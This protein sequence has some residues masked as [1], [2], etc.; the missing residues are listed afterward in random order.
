MSMKGKYQTSASIVSIGVAL[1]EGN[2]SVVGEGV[3]VGVEA[4]EV[5]VRDGVTV[6]VGVTVAA[7]ERVGVAVAGNV[8]E[9]TVGAR[10]G[11]EVAVGVAG[12]SVAVGVWVG[13]V[14]TCEP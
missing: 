12:T 6:A 4:V 14:V 5:S 11:V 8:G 7:D 3:K 1:G 13:C 10:V 2:T 9:G